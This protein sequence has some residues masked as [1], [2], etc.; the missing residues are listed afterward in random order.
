MSEIKKITYRGY[1]YAYVIRNYPEIPIDIYY[2]TAV[3]GPDRIRACLSCGKKDVKETLMRLINT[4]APKKLGRRTVEQ[5]M[6]IGE[7][8]KK[9]RR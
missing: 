9:R 6:K 2:I 4:V 3:G 8:Y 7:I 1:E 5:Q